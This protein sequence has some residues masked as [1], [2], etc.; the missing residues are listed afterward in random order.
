MTPE[1]AYLIGLLY[2]NG[3]YVEHENDTV[4]SIEFPHKKQ[5]TESGGNVQVY[6][7]ASVADIQR[8]LLPLVGT[9]LNHTQ[10]DSKT[11]IFFSLPNADPLRI[12]LVSY[13]GT[14]RSH[15]DFRL[16][17]RVFDAFSYDEKMALLRGFSDATAYIQKGN[18]YRGIDGQH[19]V[20]IQ[21]PVNWMMV[22]DICNLLK[23]VGIPVQ[24]IDWGHPNIRDGNLSY[25]NRGMH[26]SWKKE[27]Q[28]KIWANEFSPIGFTVR[29]KQE[30]LRHFADNM[31]IEPR[32]THR[33]YW[34]IQSRNQ[35]KPIHPCENDTYIPSSI[36]GRHF[37][38]WKEI[39]DALGYKL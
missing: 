18:E 35:T 21:I 26:N 37:N 11:V 20:F 9:S 25:Y 34:E 19:R 27:H 13:L 33:F 36:R 23:V 16:D 14:A 31:S 6:V 3:T 17:Q 10:Q 24:N 28:I 15:I 12:L 39:A 30:A 7:M 5:T 1:I 29:H 32:L 8:V 2:G 4:F 22:V 38:G